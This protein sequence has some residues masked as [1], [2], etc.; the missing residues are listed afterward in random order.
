MSN[1]LFIIGTDT[2]VGK[3]YVTVGLLKTLQIKGYSAIGVKPVSS[4]GT[5]INN[6]IIN[7]DALAL[8]QA[9]SVQLPYTSINP[10]SFEPAIAPHLAAGQTLLTVQNITTTLTDTLNYPCDFIL[11]EGA[12]GLAVPLNDKETLIDLLHHYAYPIILVVGIKLGCINHSLL[13]YQVMQQKKL[14][15]AGWVAN[16]I[17]KE[18]L[19]KNSIIKTIQSWLNIPFLGKIPYNGT[20]EN[21][22]LIDTL[23]KNCRVPR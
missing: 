3:T 14:H 1:K 11:I 6:R 18:T 13:T 8:Q 12:G 22:L 17:E 7:Q 21:H 23:F 19:E 20:P 5:L 16:I 2:E 4:G 15:L 9:S 10:F